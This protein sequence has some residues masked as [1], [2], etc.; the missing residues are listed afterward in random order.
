[1]NSA[2]D[3]QAAFGAEVRRRRQEQGLTCAQL[4]ARSGVHAHHIGNIEL[5]RRDVGLVLRL[6]KGLGVAPGELLPGYESLTPEGLAFARLFDSIA[7]QT[8]ARRPYRGAP[9][10]GARHCTPSAPSALPIEAHPRTIERSPR[11][12]SPTCSGARGPRATH[13]S[14]YW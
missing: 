6:A 12:R 2:A 13:R 4:S 7:D 5:G 1:M 10:C 9:V 3:A 14:R 11:R 8:A